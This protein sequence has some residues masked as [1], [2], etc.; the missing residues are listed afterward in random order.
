[1]RDW[2]ERLREF[3]AGLDMTLV[4]LEGALGVDS[5][6]LSR[7]LHGKRLPE[8]EFL[9]RLYATVERKTGTQVR[10]DVESSVRALYY[11]ACEVHEPA[12]HEV[13][14]LKD[15]VAA[16][17]RRA[18][19]AEQVAWD[20]RAQIQAEQRRREQ[21]ESGLRQLQA[22]ADAEGTDLAAVRDELQRA[23][24]ERDRLTELVAEH[25]QQ[26]AQSLIELQEVEHARGVTA[27]LLR[28]AERKLNEDLERVWMAAT[29]EEKPSKGR[30]WGRGTQTDQGPPP[31]AP[32]VGEP[33]AREVLIEMFRHLSRRN[34][35]MLKR[36]LGLLDLLEGRAQDPDDLA[37]LYK[38]DH[39]VS[40]MRR[41]GDTL[42][43]LAGEEPSRRWTRL[44]PLVDVLRAAASATEG[45]ER[46]EL[47]S[48]PNTNVIGAVV[49]DAVHLLAELLENAA[50]CSS[51]RTRVRVTGHALPDGRVLLDIDDEG[52]GFRHD[53]LAEV[54]ELLASHPPLTASA[55]ASYQMGFH[56]VSQLAQRN[57][58]RV[59]LCPG[60]TGGSRAR[61]MLPASATD[62][63]ER[64][65]APAAGGAD[66]GPH[67]SEG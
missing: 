57:G 22:R 34:Q 31:M 56:V 12:R 17:E 32:A 58:I 19:L 30:R 40:R 46:I 10:P 9:G 50:S 23:I 24:G 67:D 37:G 36:Q 63:S 1:M 62:V 49:N 59:Q 25:A 8:I 61:V 20:L 45:Y 29:A 38:L 43:V 6:T 14:V 39:L 16:A 64:R 35:E 21:I 66:S 42:L 13:Y 15:A 65:R 4:Q 55:S 52:I 44:S 47:A 11:K 51:P 18:E 41:N 5:S 33:D 48:I 26:L 7:Y 27:A 53:H 60:E 2:V 3:Y 54:N 28:D